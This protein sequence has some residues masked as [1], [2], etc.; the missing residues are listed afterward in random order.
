MY[1][2]VLEAQSIGFNNIKPGVKAFEV[3]EAVDSYIQGTKF[4]GRF[5]HSTGHSLGLSVHDNS[6]RLSSNCSTL[7]EENMVFTVEPGV[8]IPGLG[9]VRIEDDVLIK[10]DGVE[11][12][13]KSSRNLIEI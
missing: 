5:I 10:S 9:G 12:L 13:T 3:H 4:K 11:L 7:L 6:T 8:Y 1:E 2:V